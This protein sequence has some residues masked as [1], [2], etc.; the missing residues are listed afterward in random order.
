M[1]SNVG[2][3]EMF[4][5]RFYG[6]GHMVKNDSAR[7][8]TRCCHMGYSFQL[9]ARVLLY[10]LSYR[11]D[12]T[13]QR[14]CY[15]SCIALTGMRNST[16]GSPWDLDLTTHRTMSRTAYTTSFGTPVVEHWLGGWRINLMTHVTMSRLFTTEL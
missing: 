2:V 5:L 9:A 13:Y 7:E 8:E 15:A 16:M 10:A 6:I 11:Q 1:S 4:Y 3:K 14:L 12:S